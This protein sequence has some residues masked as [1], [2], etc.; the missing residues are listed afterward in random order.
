LI[1]R[2]CGNY[3]AY[4]VFELDDEP[5]LVK[6]SKFITQG[7]TSRELEHKPLDLSSITEDI[8]H[9][10]FDGEVRHPSEGMTHPN[11]EKEG[12]YSWLKSPRYNGK[13]Y[14]VGPLARLV[15][16]YAAGNTSVSSLLEPYLDELGIGA[17][18]LP[19]VIGRHLARALETKLVADSMG[20]WLLQLDIDEPAAVE[21]SIPDESEGV[22]ITEAP[23]GALGH[24]LR[25][26][27]KK[28]DNY[29]LVV[30]TTWNA[31][32][33]DADGNPGPI[34][35]ALIGTKIRDEENPFEVVR[36]VRSF[37]PCL[38]C[39]IHIVDVSG[40]TKRVMKVL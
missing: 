6:R 12:G 26:K 2:G 3:L 11:Y 15:V 24:W 1:G 16:S 23:R 36:I 37:D 8:H 22:G 10:W 35:Q 28:I 29:Q 21:V 34:E 27:D 17:G 9:S 19:S 13:P 5:D 33:T 7:T 32:P 30:P 25:I 4:G 40:R 38:A 18:D 14:E 31:G 39:A 20:E